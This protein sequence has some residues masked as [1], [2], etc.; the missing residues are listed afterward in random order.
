MRIPDDKV[1]EVKAATDIVDVVS[2]YVRLKKAGSNFKGLCPFHNEKTPSFN[3]N[4]SMGIF[5]CFGCG[6]GGNVYSFL[7]EV[8]GLGFVETV[9]MLAEKAGIE[10]PEEGAGDP[11]A[12]EK[13]SALHALRFAARWY[14]EQLTRTDTGRQ[15]GLAYFEGRGL[16]PETIKK[17]GLGFAPDAWDGLLKAAEAAQVKPEVLD[18]A[19]LVLPNKNGDGFHDR[20]RERAMFPILSHVGKVLGFGGRVLP[21]SAPP[22]GDYVPPKYINSPETRVYSKSRVLYGLFQGKQAIR[23]EEEVILVEGYTDVISL[24]QAGVEH[25]VASSGTALTPEQV[26]ALGRYAKRVLLLY[27]ADSA[28]AAAALRGIDLILREGLAAYVVALPEGSDPDS[29]VQQFGGEAF[30]NYLQKHRQSFVHFKVAAARRAGTLSTPEGQAEAARSVLDSVAQIPDTVAQDGYIRVA[31]EQLGVPDIHLRMQFRDLVKSGAS[32]PRSVPRPEPPLPED[33]GPTPV[34]FEMRPEEGALV[35]LMLEHGRPMVEHVLGRM[36]LDEFS[37]G[38]VRDLVQHLLKQYEA[39]PIDREAFVGGAFG[40][41]VQQIA[42]GVLVDRHAVSQNWQK[43]AGVGVPEL[44]GEPY[45]SAAS[46]MTLLKLDRVGEAID[47]VVRKTYAAEQAGEDLTDLQREMQQLQQLK[48]QIERRE[49][50]EWGSEA[51]A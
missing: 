18:A 38:P 31:A 37:E 13:E 34:F 8:E 6:K 33:D 19:G 5:K 24:H 46:A 36:G 26:K 15:R 41:A 29:F 22:T 4:P 1:E 9:R 16:S 21:D 11:H 12:D 39:G 10:L 44:N 42:A 28:G 40:P 14:Y 48:G 45:E 50:L 23:G 27:D 43:L 25:V 3:V 17:F 49:F 35:R 20:F 7:M 51:S 30:R 2:D 32:T 47:L